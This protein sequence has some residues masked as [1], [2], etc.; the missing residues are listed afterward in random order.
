M[1]VVVERCNILTWMHRLAQR[2]SSIGGSPH[3]IQLQEPAPS[4][5]QIKPAPK[6]R[7]V[8]L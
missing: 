7:V 1:K 8:G 5:E 2:C 6:V 4:L 3:L